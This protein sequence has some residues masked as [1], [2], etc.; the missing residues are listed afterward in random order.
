MYEVFYCSMSC[1][2]KRTEITEIPINVILVISMYCT[3][4]ERNV[5]LKKETSLYNDM[6]IPTSCII[7]GGE[8]RR[9][10]G[11]REDMACNLLPFVQV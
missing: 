11:L 4:K 10:G 7:N 3:S 8:G 5:E 6:G 1:D 2:R 9:I